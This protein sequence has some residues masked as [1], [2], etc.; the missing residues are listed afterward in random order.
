MR[1]TARAR[2]IYILNNIREVKGMT[3]EINFPLNLIIA[4]SYNAIVIK[5]V[6][7]ITRVI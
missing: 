7:L 3:R 2:F 1:Y 4:P 6:S 5:H